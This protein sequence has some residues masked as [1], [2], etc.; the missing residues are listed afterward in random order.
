MCSRRNRMLGERPRT[1]MMALPGFM[2]GRLIC[3]RRNL[4]AQQ[5]RQHPLPPTVLE[6][7]WSTMEGQGRAP[8]CAHCAR[9]QSAARRRASVRTWR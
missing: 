1:L 3:T 2:C 5:G 9:L 6:P 8:H 4:P 7:S